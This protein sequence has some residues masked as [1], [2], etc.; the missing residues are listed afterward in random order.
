M[1]E[2]DRLTTE[3]Y[4][5]P[6]L[7]LMEN[8]AQA[9]AR[10]ICQRLGGSVE[11]SSILILCGKGNNGG[12]GAALARILWTQ[13]ANVEVCLIGMVSATS[14]DARTNFEILRK[15]ADRETFELDQADLALEEIASIEE[16]MEYDSLNFQADEPDVIVDALFGTGLTHSLEGVYAEVAAF[17][18]TY[19]VEPD[20]P[21]VVALDIPSGL[22]ADS[23]KV[24][25][26]VPCADVTVTFT[27]PKPANILPP[28]SRYN[29]DLAI[30]DIGSPCELVNMANAKLYLATRE[31]AQRWLA[32]TEF[33][34][35]S[36]KFRR[37]HA[38]II[39]GSA[40]YSG[41]AVLCGDA[42]IR[43]GVGL[44]TIA[45]PESSRLAIVGRVQPEIM[46]RGVAETKKGSIS[47]DALPEVKEF[48]ERKITAVAIGSGMSHDEETTRKFIRSV[49]EKRTT[50][51]VIDA[52]GLNALA[53][54]DLAGDADHPIILTPHYGEFKRLIGT[55]GEIDDTVAAVREF[56]QVHKIF[57]VLKGERTLIADPSGCVVV[58][59]T[60]N[61]GLGKAGNGDTLTGFLVGFVAQA[62]ALDI[63]IFET[64]VAGVYIAGLAGDIA[65][66]KYGKR[67]MIASDV[68][69]CMHD[70]LIAVAEE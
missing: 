41:A 8:A 11:D 32:A 15:I 61:S 59:P 68:R 7:L 23:A 10:V 57:V 67:I 63:G 22:S 6:S 55:E 20:G 17:I 47:E 50:P 44:A 1:R 48:T 53:P 39:A 3:E 19:G 9:A 26:I 66:E 56:A 25:G 49:V 65:E 12:D 21:L 34:P 69:D 36:Y 45:C 29:G 24:D 14:G 16:W 38:L 13:G 58:N 30:A 4:G 5:I 60:G 51:V 70:A 54:F 27:S 18:H 2:V 62:A 46:V 35:D 40:D 33:T 28:A 31:D 64:L 37:G 42:A 43:S 52:D